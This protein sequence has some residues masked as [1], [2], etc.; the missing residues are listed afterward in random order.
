MSEHDNDAMP[1]LL[2]DAEDVKALEEAW[3]KRKLDEEEKNARERRLLDLPDAE[4][5]ALPADVR[6]EVLGCPVQEILVDDLA[7]ERQRLNDLVEAER[8]RQA[9]QREPPDVEPKGR[10]RASRKMVKDIEQETGRAVRVVTYGA[11]GSRKFEFGQ[12][13]ADNNADADVDAW[14]KKEKHA[15]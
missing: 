13:D 3:A 6:A 9:G 7:I 10:V 11:D 2:L 14:L 1:E 5:L 4:W 8:Q 12:P 15:H